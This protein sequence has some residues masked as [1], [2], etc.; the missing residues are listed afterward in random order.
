[1]TIYVVTLTAV[2]DH[3]CLGVFTD[4]ETAKAH[5]QNLWAESDGHHSFR[6]D[7]VTLD[8]PIDS[9]YLRPDYP[10]DW[11]TKRKATL[12]PAEYIVTPQGD[13]DE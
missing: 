13:T 10:T 2:Y 4:L 1:M 8:R 12:L 5:C 6:I 3:G 9:E 7:T 11:A